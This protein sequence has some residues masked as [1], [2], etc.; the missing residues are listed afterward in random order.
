VRGGSRNCPYYACAKGTDPLLGCDSA[1]SGRCYVTPAT[2]TCNNRTTGLCNPFLSNGSVNTCSR[3]RTRAQQLNGGVFYLG[4]RRGL[5]YATTRGTRLVNNRG[6]FL[7][8]PCRGVILKRTGATVQLR[9]QLCGVLTS[10]QRKL[11][12]LHC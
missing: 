2:Y 11:R 10:G 8:G 12:N 7:H 3:K 1:K 4:P 9:D 5:C 6:S